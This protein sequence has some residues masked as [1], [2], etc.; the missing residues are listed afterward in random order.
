MTFKEL[1]ELFCAFLTPIISFTTVYIAYQQW[2]TNKQ[3][4]DFDRYDRRIRIYEEVQKILSVV[5]QDGHSSYPSL[6]AFL[7]RASEAD[8]LF[9]EDVTNYIREIFKRGITVVSVDGKFD[10][11]KEETLNWFLNQHDFAKTLF[12]KYMQIK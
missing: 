7:S 10:E 3:K 8:F 6:I 5:I 12:K 9:D 11:K 4:L 1:I 2:K